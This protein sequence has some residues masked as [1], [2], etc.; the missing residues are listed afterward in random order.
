MLQIAVGLVAP[1]PV[2]QIVGDLNHDRAIDVFDAIMI[3]QYI[4][5]SAEVNGCGPP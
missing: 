4:V 3:L 1:T 2:Q 5:G